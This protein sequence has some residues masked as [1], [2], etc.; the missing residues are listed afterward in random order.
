MCEIWL[1]SYVFLYVGIFTS[2]IDNARRATEGTPHYTAHQLRPESFA[3]ISAWNYYSWPTV[4][5]YSGESIRRQNTLSKQTVQSFF[6]FF[7]FLVVAMR[8]L[9][10]HRRIIRPLMRSR[11][12]T[13]LLLIDDVFVEFS[14]SHERM[15]SYILIY[16]LGVKW[17][18][19]VL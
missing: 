5:L 17:I 8:P 19:T 11:V 13:C 14:C 15:I 10:L 12:C 6:F 18:N 7:T 9:V 3:L 2:K 4:P 1:W 16:H